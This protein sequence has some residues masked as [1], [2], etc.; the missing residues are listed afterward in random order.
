MPGVGLGKRRLALFGACQASPASQ[1]KPLP[2]A[3][4]QPELARPKKRLPSQWSQLTVA[5]IPRD[6][7]SVVLVVSV[8]SVSKAPA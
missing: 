2:A 4:H 1:A 5:L 6:F 8:V 7:V 3:L